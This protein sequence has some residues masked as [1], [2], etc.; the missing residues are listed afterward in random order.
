VGFSVAPKP[1]LPLLVLILNYYEG[2]GSKRNEPSENGVIGPE[3]FR[4]GVGLEP[5]PV[6]DNFYQMYVL[7]PHSG[8]RKKN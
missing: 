6:E 1:R 4:D 2:R 3:K 8:L 5:V 7:I